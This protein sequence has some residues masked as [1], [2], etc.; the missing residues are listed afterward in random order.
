VSPF[1]FNAM[2]MSKSHWVSALLLAA[3]SSG[4]AAQT[5][6]QRCTSLVNGAPAGWRVL[7]ATFHAEPATAELRLPP[8]LARSFSLPA[9]C[10]ILAATPDRAGANGQVYAIQ[11]RLRMPVK[12]NER[13]VYQGGGG[14]NGK[15]G[16]AYGVLDAEGRT[17]IEQGYAVLSQDSGHDNARNADPAYN[18]ELAFGFDPVARADYGHASLAPSARAGLDLVS[19][20]YGR[21]PRYRYFVGCSKGGQ[22]GLAFAQRYPAFFDGIVAAAPGM[23]LPR[24]ALA[25][26][27]DTQA[28]GR[29]QQQMAADGR[30]DAMRLPDTFHR[31]QLGRVRQAVLDACDADDGLRDG[32]VGDPK[33]CTDPKVRVQLAKA[34]CGADNTAADC[35]R[36]EQVQALETSI[37]G[38]R[39]AQGRALY[40]RWFWPSGIDADAWRVWKIGLEGNVVPA[41]NVVLGARA[42]AS[43][44]T[45]PPVA[46]PPHPPG[47][48]AWQM[49]FDFTRDA[50]K[51]DAVAPPFERSAWQD[52]SARS[53]DLDA[54]AKR[55]GKLLVPH[56][57]SDAVFSLADT[58]DWYDALNRRAGGRAASF[59]RV[60][61]VPGMSHCGGGPA[62]DSYDA[63]GALV[64]WVEHG[65]APERLEARAGAATPWPGRT[66]P[67]CPYPKVARYLGR[68]DVESAASFACVA[69]KA[70]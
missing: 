13:W 7:Q 5:A 30:F 12:W 56:G 54:F 59:A 22:E 65:Q 45:T 38:P 61:P 31:A 49:A 66:R 34:M 23:S 47:M 67:L 53:T 8:A 28:F 26:A 37:A 43:V 44:M 20:Y 33:A 6:E 9:H 62:T 50:S 14:S 58:L 40:A 60:F 27:W 32:I 35:L 63:L 52:V 15:V 48:A 18:G 25:Q 64:R 41:L 69:P 42:L 70:R 68:G 29:L 10:E 39:D 11:L 3:A 1:R 16:D 17:A 24:A 51:I 36:P 55:G 57:E 19:R 46:L 2:K 4:V 21:A